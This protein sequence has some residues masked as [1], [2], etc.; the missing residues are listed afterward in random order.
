MAWTTPKT[1]SNEPLVAG[2]LNTHLRDNMEAL[3]DPPSEQVVL[4]EASNY[5]TSST[6]F[7][8]VDNTVLSL[9]LETNGGDV[10]VHFH[11]TVSMSANVFSMC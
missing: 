11:A 7:V 10:M 4:D 8:D 9:T 1:W 3:K 6:V 5:S 2:D